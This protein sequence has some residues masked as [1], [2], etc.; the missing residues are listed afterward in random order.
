M[1]K[2]GHDIARNF[3]TSENASS[4]NNV[5]KFATF[6]FD[7]LW[8]REMSKL[9]N[10]DDK[11]VLDLACGTGIMGPLLLSNKL[12]TLIGS[13]LVFEYLLH[14]K[15]LGYS[16]LTNS[17]AEYLPYKSGTFDVVISSY[18]VKYANL[19]LTTE[20]HWRILKEGGIVIF[21][22]FSYP[23]NKLIKSLWICYFMILNGIGKILTSWSNAFSELDKV[24]KESHWTS[25]LVSELEK[26]GFISIIKRYY[27]LGT[28]AI[29]Y[30]TKPLS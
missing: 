2:N 16:L 30:A 15:K 21:H 12:R 28:S 23:N 14:A 20:Q 11:C 7:S 17:V 13:D 27:T 3:F 8:K 9:I 26:Q 4:Y 29:V 24:I 1:N 18:L 6:G 5:V 19:K 10:L 22:D 25:D